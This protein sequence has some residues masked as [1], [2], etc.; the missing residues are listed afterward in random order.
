M[1]TKAEIQAAAR[2]AYQEKRLLAFYP[3]LS[4][5][6]HHDEGKCCAIGAAYTPEDNL[7][8]Y[9]EQHKVYRIGALNDLLPEALQIVEADLAWAIELQT[10]H[11][12]WAGEEGSDRVA[13]F[14]EALEA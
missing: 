9:A 10:T 2:L 3:E 11:D 4:V 7:D 5:V 1:K 12:N 14:L 8:V 6:Y 13:L